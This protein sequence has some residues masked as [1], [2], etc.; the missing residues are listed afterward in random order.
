MGRSGYQSGDALKRATSHYNAPQGHI[1]LSHARAHAPA[2]FPIFAPTHAHARAHTPR[3]TL[4]APIA[5]RPAPERAPKRTHRPRPHPADIGG[6]LSIA[7]GAGIGMDRGGEGVKPSS[8]CII[9]KA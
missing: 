9:Y 5:P 4:R 1:R 8:N 2:R 7:G 3:H 6:Y